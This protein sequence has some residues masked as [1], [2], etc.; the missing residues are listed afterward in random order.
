MKISSFKGGMVRKRKYWAAVSTQYASSW[1]LCRCICAWKT[2]YIVLLHSYVS[3]CVAQGGSMSHFTAQPCK[4]TLITWDHHACYGS[5]LY[6]PR[7]CLGWRHSGT[8]MDPGRYVM[9]QDCN[10]SST[11]EISIMFFQVSNTFNCLL[12]WHGPSRIQQNAFLC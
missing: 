2:V 12:L 4:R 8:L 9:V 10:E 6:L 5:A 1:V 7:L 3:V 11:L